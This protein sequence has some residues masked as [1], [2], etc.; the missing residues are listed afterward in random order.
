MKELEEAKSLVDNFLEEAN[1]FIEKMKE[2][3]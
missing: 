1:E 3:K 2:S